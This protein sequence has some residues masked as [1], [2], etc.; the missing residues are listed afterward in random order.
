MFSNRIRA[1]THSTAL[2]F[3]ASILVETAY[4]FDPFT[5]SAVVSAG[6]EVVGVISDVTSEVA[7]TS[8]SFSEL[9]NEI[10]SEAQVNQEGLRAIQELREIES[11]AREAGYSK[12]EIENLMSESGESSSEKSLSAT[13]RTVTSAIRAGK[14]ASRLVMKLDKKAQ[15]AEIES[16]EIQREELITHYRQLRLEHERDLRELKERVSHDLEK[17]KVIT[18][19]RREEKMTGAKAFGRTGILSF[20]KQDR[21]IEEALK[22][23]TSMRPVL[24]SLILVV[25]MIRA[26]AYQFSFGNTA[27]YGDLVRDVVVCSVLLMVFPELIKMTLSLANNLASS[28]GFGSLQEVEPSKVELGEAQGVSLKLRLL[29]EWGLEWVKYG[30]FVF[31]RFIANFGLGFLILLFPVIIFSSQML[32]FTLAWPVFFG[33][34][35]AICLWPLFWNATG[36][37]AV[38]L[39]QKQDLALSDR[40]TALLFSV[41][42]FLSPLIGVACL[43]GQ[44]VSKAAQ[45]AVASVGAAVTGGGRFGFSQAEGFGKGSLGL[46]GGGMI[47]QM[48]AYPFSQGTG[49]LMAAAT[50]GLEVRKSADSNG[51]HASTASG[52]AI[53]P[54]KNGWRPVLKAMASAALTNQA[55]APDLDDGKLGVLKNVALGLKRKPLVGLNQKRKGA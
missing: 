26:I 33:G 22:M 1:L 2:A 6:A 38:L 50:R 14:Q 25:F 34:F 15:L 17:R 27:K 55:N 3:L 35:I 52:T 11:M 5:I 24:F 16:V 21:V 8:D 46:P 45:S 32:N 20:P 43:K 53:P 40:F 29:L 54:A 51:I 9:Y 18:A 28:V 4:G 23:A 37:L 36:S 30:A 31:A 44:A 39:W 10:D 7:S 41:L 47:G 48:L 42:Q 12:N 13:I 19:L 49:R